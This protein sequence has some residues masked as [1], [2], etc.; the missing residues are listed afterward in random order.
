[1]GQLDLKVSDSRR[2]MIKKLLTTRMT[3]RLL[4]EDIDYEKIRLREGGNKLLADIV[5]TIVKEEG[6]LNSTLKQVRQ[7]I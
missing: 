2:T 6:K 1:M 3:D 4:D 7:H 5:D